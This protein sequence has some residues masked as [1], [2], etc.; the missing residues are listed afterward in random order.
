M[1]HTVELVRKITK[2]EYK[3]LKTISNKQST[4]DIRQYGF[5][6]FA[7]FYFPKENF[8]TLDKYVKVQYYIKIKLN[9]SRLIGK[10]R[11]N[12]L[13]PEP[14]FLRIKHNFHNVLYNFIHSN[15]KREQLNILNGISAA[16]NYI[17]PI[18]YFDDIGDIALLCDIDT[19]RALR[20]DYT[21]QYNYTKEEAD[22]VEKYITLFQLGDI[23]HKY[24]TKFRCFKNINNKPK[25]GS[26]YY[27]QLK[28]ARDKNK[29]VIIDKKTGEPKIIRNNKAYTVN[30][31]DK[32]NQLE[33]ERKDNIKKYG[34][35]YITDELIESARGKLRLEIQCGYQALY[36]IRKSF[37]NAENK[38]KDFFEF[39]EIPLDY[40]NLNNLN[41][42]VTNGA[43]IANKVISRFFLE[44][45]QT[46]NYYTKKRGLWLIENKSKAHNNNKEK[47]KELFMLVIPDNHRRYSI[48][49]VREELEQGSLRTRGKTIKA[50]DLDSILKNFDKIG[51]NVVALPTQFNCEL[52][53]SYENIFY[54]IAENTTD[55]L[56]W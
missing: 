51:V 11:L 6:E 31:Y 26:C 49:E 23:P 42:F 47:M 35:S 16:E 29:E 10:E 45:S 5:N 22:K 36:S 9:L 7:C 25:Y 12:V 1:I 41:F 44:I 43:E 21:V 30:F 24:G 3:I 32:A 48:R 13:E 37:A 17:I 46:G 33:N 52:L 54:K 38:K 28:K 39:E 19:Y 27:M 2:E 15:L 40:K 53:E 56:N 55:Y 8:E 34:Y 4:K 18:D 20:I 50:K 14:S